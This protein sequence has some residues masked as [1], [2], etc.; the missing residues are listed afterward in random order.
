MRPGAWD[1]PN[2]DSYPFTLSLGPRIV[3]QTFYLGQ[4]LG[5]GHPDS[6]HGSRSLSSPGDR[7]FAIAKA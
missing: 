6:H 2:L 7:I 1:P 4:L 3:F 5:F